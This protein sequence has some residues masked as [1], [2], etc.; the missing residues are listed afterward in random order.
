[1]SEFQINE[2]QALTG[3]LLSALSSQNLFPLGSSE[4]I[5]IESIGSDLVVLNFILGSW[6]P[7]CMKHI[8]D[9]STALLNM[10]KSKFKII[11]VTTEREK[12]LRDSLIRVSEGGFSSENIYFIPGAS[13]NLLNAFSLRIPLFGFSKPATFLLENLNT[14]KM[15]SRGIPNK[16]KV[17]C[18]LTGYFSKKTA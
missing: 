9:I 13:K 7:L 1:M 4:T 3:E 18:D 5:K 12:T 15:L 10:G 11:V 17:V 14:V 8:I 16:E 2:E 6:C